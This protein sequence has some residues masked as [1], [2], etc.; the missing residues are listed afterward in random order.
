M[1]QSQRE[2]IKRYLMRGRKLTHI[3]ALDKFG[4]ARLAS[5]IHEVRQDIQRYRLPYLLH[6]KMIKTPS[7]IYIAQYW[8]EKKRK[9]N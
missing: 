6:S 3:Q 2:L 7:G 8:M 5:R 9:I 4:C 1:S